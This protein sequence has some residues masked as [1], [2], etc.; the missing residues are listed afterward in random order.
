MHQVSCFF[1][2]TRL[3][4][5]EGGSIFF[6]GAPRKFEHIRVSAYASSI[7]WCVVDSFSLF[8]SYKSKSGGFWN[9]LLWGC[10]RAARPSAAPECLTRCNDSSSRGRY[11]FIKRIMTLQRS[12]AGQQRQHEIFIDNHTTGC[13]HCGTREKRAAGM[14]RNKRERTMLTLQR[15]SPDLRTTRRRH[16]QPLLLNYA[17]SADKS[18]G[19]AANFT[20]FL[21]FPAILWTDKVGRATQT[22]QA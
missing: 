15:E 7:R 1:S 17:Q 21:N 8:F 22:I 5:D 9:R 13:L 12:N 19:S 6:Y 20:F 18:T 16:A 3:F 11:I 2:S 14:K 10:E 4:S